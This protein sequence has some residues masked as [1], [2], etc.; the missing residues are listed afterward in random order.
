MA[1]PGPAI[2]GVA[3]VV[4]AFS[5]SLLAAEKY[6][7]VYGSGKLQLV[8]ATGSPGE[9]GLVEALSV[10]FARKADVTVKWKKAGT[11]SGLRLLK[12]KK[13]DLIL[14]HDP[15]AEKAAVQEG[16]AARR[17]LVGSN[18]FWI[19]G[20]VADP[21]RIAS[22]ITADAA[23]RKIA[24]KQARFFSRGESSG[25]H[26]R[27]LLIWK[28]AKISPSGA[29]YRPTKSFMKET[30]KRASDEQ[31]YTI[32]DNS[33]WLM[34][35]ASRRDLKVLFRGGPLLL[36][37]YHALCR[38]GTDDHARTASRFIDFMVSPE[39]QAVVGEYG[40]AR[41]GLPLYNDAARTKQ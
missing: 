7:G 8:L 25:T 30:L 24:A 39:G 3:L 28:A 18:E 37:S 17:E 4:L 16:W 23:L 15:A 27:E 33:T 20:P 21:A 9:L 40:K 6:D 38:P 34:E 29:W 36:N 31:G 13:I 12:Q 19:V 11:G 26:E 1:R 10:A 32:T 2:L 14:A 5:G 35:E 41:F 22:A